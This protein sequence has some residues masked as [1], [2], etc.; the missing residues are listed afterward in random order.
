MR[1]ITD[2]KE[3]RSI[4]LSL[5]SEVKKICEEN[6][7][8]YYLS[9]GTLLGAVRHKGFIPWDDDIDMHMPRPDYE[10]FIEIY[11][12][13]G[14]QNVLHAQ[15]LNPDYQYSFI[16]I[17]AKDTIL[18]EKGAH[19]GVEMGVYIDIFPIDG[20]GDKIED[21]HKIF[22]KIDLPIKLLMS[23]RVNKIRK[24]VSFAKNCLVIGASIVASFFGPKKLSKII[25]E[26]AKTYDFDKSKLVGSFIDEV[27]DNRIYEKELYEGQCELE[28]EGVMFSVPQGYKTILTKFYGDYMK[29]PPKEKQVFTHGY[30][31][32]IK[33][34]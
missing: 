32:Y 22:R 17:A 33:E 29:L 30:D 26:T 10:K 3:L 6:N 14:G 34:D 4:L 9:G 25:A 21:A 7:L 19:C 20:L 18:Y 1:K 23:Y 15:E 31:A 13:A 28:F 11:Y 16:K 27:G 5:A 24:H 12:K 2:I 8:R